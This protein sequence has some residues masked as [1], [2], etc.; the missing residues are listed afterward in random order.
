V[1]TLYLEL[2]DKLDSNFAERKYLLT[3]Y[4]KIETT[5]LLS[6]AKT[7]SFTIP[8]YSDI[9]EE[10][11][12]KFN[13][14]KYVI[15]NISINNR[16]LEMD[17]QCEG[18]YSLLIDYIVMPA[19]GDGERLSG[20]MQAIMDRLLSGTGWTAVCDSFGSWDFAYENLYSKSVLECI[21]YVKDNFNSTTVELDFIDNVVYVR[22]QLGSDTRIQI[23]YSTNMD[24]LE[25]F[26]D[27]TNLITRMIVRGSESMELIGYDLTGKSQTGFTCVNNIV[28]K[29]YVDAATINNYA[30][31]KM[32]LLIFEDIMTQA[33]LYN[34]MVSIRSTLGVPLVSYKCSY[35]NLYKL[36]INYTDIAL[37]DTIT[38]VDSTLGVINVR[39][40]EIQENP[41][42]MDLSQVTLATRKE[43]IMSYLTDLNATK[44]D[45]SSYKIKNATKFVALENTLTGINNVLNGSGSNVEYTADHLKSW[46]EATPSKFL[47]IANGVLGITTDNGATLKTA[48]D[49]SGVY[50]DVL[51]GNLLVGAN[52]KFGNIN[53]YADINNP[54]NPK[55]VIGEISAGVYGLKVAGGSLEITGGLGDSNINS[56]STWNGAVSTANSAYG[57][58]STSVQQNT[59]YNK[60]KITPT[61]GL[62]VFDAGNNERVKIGS[63]D[64]GQYG[65]QL[66]NTSGTVVMNQDSSGNLA[67]TGSITATSGSFTGSLYAANLY[68]DNGSGSYVS[69]LDSSLTKVAGAKINAKGISVSDGSRTT[70]SVDTNGN[71]SIYGNITMT[72][73]SISWANVTKPSYSASEV[74]AV[75]TSTTVNGKALSSN[76][77]LSATDVS[78][79]AANWVPSQSDLGSWTT[80]I[81]ANG[82]YTGNLTGNT[83]QT[84]LINN[85]RIVLNGTG[86][87]TYNS[88]NVQHGVELD[89]TAGFSSVNFWQSG[90]NIGYVGYSGGNLWLNGTGS[91]TII[92]SDNS[93]IWLR[94]G[95]GNGNLG[96]TYLYGTTD[97]TNTTFVGTKKIVVQSN[98][99][100]GDSNVIWIKI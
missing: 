1:A 50:A 10:W 47:K 45:L 75:S 87:K 65:L 29:S 74:G 61:Y 48:I 85:K 99:P 62:Q 68:L 38:I 6:G 28:T 23:N 24:L 32:G 56:A 73:G 79:R 37:G 41:I 80:Y 91:R 5:R 94:P 16:S 51:A 26:I 15:R 27:S 66:K 78:A 13:G 33:D 9:T 3:N 86:L 22:S 81:D 17:C 83:I 2:F 44:S 36:G 60:V 11:F 88:S 98:A 70:F 40:V 57:L 42:S 54:T 77:T 53:V 55:V 58:A 100:T 34:K 14:V 18:L 39:V 59:F 76:I 43:D 31:P 64:N 20:T 67:L 63:M 90:S 82:I 12:V 89:V 25:K 8:Y 69:M 72:G 95:T 96:S 19:V 4:T 7:L 21:N 46:N 30:N 71:V 35:L 92:N 52:G 84:N 49:G 93:D 97:V